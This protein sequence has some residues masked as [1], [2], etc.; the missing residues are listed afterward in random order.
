MEE[1]DRAAMNSHYL[2]R[3]YINQRRLSSFAYQVGCVLDL[4][5]R[6]V[7]EV[8]VGSG[9]VGSILTRLGIIVSSLDVDSSL[10]PK[11]VGSVTQIPLRSK[12][13]D[14]VLCCEVLEH[15]PFAHLELAL[16]ELSRTASRGVVISLPNISPYYRIS[17]SLPVI[18]SF[19]ASCSVGFGNSRSDRDLNP[20]HCWEIGRFG[21]SVSRISSLMHQAGLEVERTFRNPNHAYHHFFICRPK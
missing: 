5:P 20:S 8:G 6:S 1:D 2:K 3:D 21:V 17:G 7:L 14:A 12:S 15:L 16:S 9:S 4:N 18:G 13:V 11:V 10:S 19:E